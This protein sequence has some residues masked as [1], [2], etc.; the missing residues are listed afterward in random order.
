MNILFSGSELLLPH[1]KGVKVY[2]YGEWKENKA[3]PQQHGT[4]LLARQST[5]TLLGFSCAQ[6]EHLGK[7][8]LATAKNLPFLSALVVITSNYCTEKK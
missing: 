8:T 3:H 1:R 4:S 7:A 2:H 6:Q 5:A